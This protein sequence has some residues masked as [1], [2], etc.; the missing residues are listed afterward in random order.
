M[1]VNCFICCCGVELRCQL[2]ATTGPTGAASKQTCRVQLEGAFGQIKEL[3]AQLAATKMQLNSAI[4]LQYSLDEQGSA[5][6]QDTETAKA[7]AAAAESTCSI[8]REQLTYM[9]HELESTVEHVQGSASDAAQS[10]MD[11]AQAQLAEVHRQ[12]QQVT[13]ER[14]RRCAPVHCLTRR[15]CAPCAEQLSA[16]DG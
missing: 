1:N 9:R 3:G 10:A 5:A 2:F 16:G 12:L 6:Q 11:S 15:T 8:L 14:V 13:D 7:A 4:E